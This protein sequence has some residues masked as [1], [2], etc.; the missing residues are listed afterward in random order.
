MNTTQPPD[1]DYFPF[2]GPIRL[3]HLFIFTAGVCVL[4]ALS[5]ELGIFRGIVTSFAVAT[6]VAAILQRS[7]RSVVWAVVGVLLVALFLP[8]IHS[9]GGSSRRSDCINNLRHIGL[10]IMAYESRYGSLPPAYIAD[11]QG[12]PMHSWRVLL[13]PFL[14]QNALYRKYRFDEPWDGPNNRLLH[15]EAPYFFHCRSDD[16]SPENHTSYF[17]VLGPDTMWTPG[18]P[19]HFKDITDGHGNTILVVE[20]HDAGV[21]WMEPRDVNATTYMSEQQAGIATHDPWHACVLWANGRA[22]RIDE[23]TTPEQLKEMFTPA[24]GEPNPSEQ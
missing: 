3:I 22:G 23:E 17:A 24:G 18:T 21:H 10:A 13:L 6:I 8:S 19:H 9:T 14:E 5:K 12:R 2:G 4:I 20:R 11:D 7:R 16:R 15:A 1:G